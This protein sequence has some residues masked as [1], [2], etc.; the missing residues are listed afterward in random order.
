[1]KAR[2]EELQNDLCQLRELVKRMEVLGCKE[3][4]H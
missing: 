3:L 2:S 4:T 1:M